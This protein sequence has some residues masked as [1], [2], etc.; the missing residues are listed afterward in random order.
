[1]L[2]L[3]GMRS[4]QVD[5]SARTVAAGPGTLWS[6]LDAATGEFGLANTGG[7]VGSTGIAGLT[8]GGGVGWL[9]RFTGL[10]CDNL[11]GAAAPTTNG[12]APRTA[13]TIHGWHGSSPPTTR[14]TSSISTT[15]SRRLSR[16]KRRPGRRRRCHL[17][18]CAVRN[19]HTCQ[20]L[21]PS[22]VGS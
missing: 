15:T 14:T 22:G 1:M 13:A 8:L 21:G 9:D 6:Q 20:R 12:S 3:S 4:V 10:T 18:M 5:P 11:L 16:R 2:D 19:V 7:V 17:M